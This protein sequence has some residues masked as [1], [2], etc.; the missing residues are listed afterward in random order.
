MP[1]VAVVAVVAVIAIVALT[2][3]VV[4]SATGAVVGRFH[5]ADFISE[6]HQAGSIQQ[7]EVDSIDQIL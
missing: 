3:V 6:V 1:L 5:R 2:A 7:N 4:V